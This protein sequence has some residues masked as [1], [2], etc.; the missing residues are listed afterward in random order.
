MQVAEGLADSG[1]ADDKLRYGSAESNE[2]L[3][4]YQHHG[5]F[6]HLRYVGTDNGKMDVARAHI[7]AAYSKGKT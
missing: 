7:Y 5:T 1:T 2:P 4:S 3:E 6:Y